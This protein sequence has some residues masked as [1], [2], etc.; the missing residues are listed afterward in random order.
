MKPNSL[1]PDYTLIIIKISI[2]MSQKKQ[3]RR[4]VREAQQRRQANRIINGIFI[5]LI[6]IM[7][8]ALLAYWFV[9]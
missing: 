5:A 6:L 7:V 2:T 3:L 1:V 4:N 8:L 9:Q